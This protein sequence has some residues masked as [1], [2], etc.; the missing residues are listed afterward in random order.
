MPPVLKRTNNNEKSSCFYSAEINLEKV[1]INSTKTLDANNV[2]T[3]IKVGARTKY[4][5]EKVSS[6]L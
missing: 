2:D 4:K 5:F 6:E 3:I 1:E